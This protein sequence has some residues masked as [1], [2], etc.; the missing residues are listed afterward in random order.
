[1]TLVAFLRGVNVSGRKPV[2]MADLAAL[3]E[4][5]GFKNVR[6]YIQSGNVVFDS[7]AKD[8]RK[9]GSLIGEAIIKKYG[10]DVT[11]IVRTADELG[12]IIAGNPLLKDSGVDEDRLHVTILEAAPE[13]GVVAGLAM[14]ESKNE[15][16]QVKGNEVYLYC[17]DGY[18][19]SKLNNTAFEKKL[20]V[21]ATTR[22]W[23]TI[24]A[25]YEMTRR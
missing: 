12:K 17:P 3:V 15:K 13:K 14:G 25:L 11:V 9:A 19:R 18:G 22:T 4:S 24:R 8:T 21:P 10:F 5:L 6:T 16:F 20:G 7:P 23:K 2:K 1:M